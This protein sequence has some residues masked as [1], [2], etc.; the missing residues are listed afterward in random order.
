MGTLIGILSHQ[1]IARVTDRNFTLITPG[2][3]VSAGSMGVLGRTTYPGLPV[4]TYRRPVAAIL[5]QA[6]WRQDGTTV[7]M[8]SP[9]WHRPLRTSNRRSCVVR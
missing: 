2:F 4:S 9:E 7:E 6:V 5:P 8:G 1:Y 3:F